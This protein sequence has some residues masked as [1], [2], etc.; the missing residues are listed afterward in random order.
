MCEPK[1]LEAA[2]RTRRCP[3]TTSQKY[4]L[5]AASWNLLE[6]A[7]MISLFIL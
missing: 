5:S 1:A 4:L 2:M 7:D 6:D 3:M